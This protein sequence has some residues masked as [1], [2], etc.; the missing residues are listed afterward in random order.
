MTRPGQPAT[1]PDFAGRTAI[2]TGGA[3]GIGLAC[4]TR[5]HGLG[6]RVAI[7]DIDAAR[8][9]RAAATLGQRATGDMVD[10]TSES[11]IADALARTASTLGVPDILVASAGVNG[12]T[13]PTADYPLAEFRRVLDIDLTG[14]FLC[15]RAVVPGMTARGYG[16][17]VNIASIAGKEANA[18]AVAYAAAKAG[19][20]AMTQSLAKEVAGRGVLVNA[21]APALIRTELFGQMTD[22]W[23][24]AMTS[25]IPMGRPGTVDEVAALVCWLASDACSFSSG[26]TFDLS[27]G[28]ATW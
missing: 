27:G 6:A 23:I 19:V 1:T 10:V 14:V 12:L 9:A 4:A 22:A 13:G 5:L 25:K 8:A 21:V 7:W 18:G 11:S 3:S 26:A 24:A 20:M 16:R 17:I 15:D 28:R 2:V